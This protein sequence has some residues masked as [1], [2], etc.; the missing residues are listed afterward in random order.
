MTAPS[1]VEDVISDLRYKNG[2]LYLFKGGPCVKLTCTYWKTG[3]EKGF[4]TKRIYDSLSIRAGAKKAKLPWNDQIPI[5]LEHFKRYEALAYQTE[6]CFP[7]GKLFSCFEV[8]RKDNKNY[9]NPKA[10]DFKCKVA[11]ALQKIE[12]PI[13]PTAVINLAEN[14]CPLVIQPQAEILNDPQQ[15]TEEPMLIES[16]DPQQGTEEPMLIESEDPQQVQDATL[17]EVVEVTTSQKRK[18]SSSGEAS[19]PLKPKCLDALPSKR[20]SKLKQL[21]AEGLATQGVNPKK[22]DV[23]KLLE[24]VMGYLSQNEQVILLFPGLM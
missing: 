3:S 4:I 22:I 13:L 17:T 8:R 20:R 24:I 15:V 7:E 5:C 11:I 21:F 10:F 19:P 14:V 16:E 18:R 9:Y 23:D 12:S 6:G 2:R 1:K